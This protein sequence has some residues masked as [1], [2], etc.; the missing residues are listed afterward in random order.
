MP[1]SQEPGDDAIY[2]QTKKCLAIFRELGES[3]LSENAQG[4]PSVRHTAER[5]RKWCDSSY[6]HL[7]GLLSLDER[8]RYATSIHQAV[9]ECL[10]VVIESLEQVKDTAQL[11]A[12]SKGMIIPYWRF[13]SSQAQIHSQGNKAE[14]N[15]HKAQSMEELAL[16]KLLARHNLYNPITHTNSM[17][18]MLQRI[19][20]R[21]RPG[22]S[23]DRYIK[24]QATT[25]EDHEVFR[26]GDEEHITHTFPMIDPKL[27]ARLVS[28]SLQRRRLLQYTLKRYEDFRI[29]EESAAAEVGQDQNRV[30]LPVGKRVTS[31]DTDSIISHVS[32]SRTLSGIMNFQLTG[33]PSETS[34]MSA[35]SVTDSRQNFRFPPFPDENDNGHRI[36]P[37]CF[38]LLPFPSEAEWR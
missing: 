32:S 37:V 34:S 5:F 22:L 17:I 1:D 9:L 3:N 4:E 25:L 31:F 6:A 14:F 16:M 36:C 8:L 30:E 33:P 26:C 24:A 11:D 27:R 7:P 20:D 18:D 35:I 21:I 28:A 23:P 13:S 2:K 15:Q 38:L 10:E 12:S 19:N 29:V